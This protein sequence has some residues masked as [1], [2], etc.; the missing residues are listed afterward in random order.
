MLTGKA[1][2]FGVSLTGAGKGMPGRPLKVF[3]GVSGAP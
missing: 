3:P 2:R 1:E